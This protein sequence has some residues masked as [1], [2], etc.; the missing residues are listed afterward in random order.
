MTAAVA[1]PSSVMEGRGRSFDAN[2]IAGEHGYQQNNEQVSGRDSGIPVE[3]PFT[4]YGVNPHP[5]FADAESANGTVDETANQEE[6]SPH[7]SFVDSAADQEQ[8][9]DASPL[10]ETEARVQAEID[11]MLSAPMEATT[12]MGGEELDLASPESA[13]SENQYSQNIQVQGLRVTEGYPNQALSKSIPIVAGTPDLN[14]PADTC[15]EIQGDGENFAGSEVPS[16]HHTT[17]DTTI[18]ISTKN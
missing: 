1:T 2:T 9:G 18:G 4:Q 5:H 8:F 17:N 14:S 10:S 11:Q 6:A 16:T 12:A 15:G 13:S 7:Q 3:D